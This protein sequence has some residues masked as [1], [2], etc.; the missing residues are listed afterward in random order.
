M[1]AVPAAAGSAVVV[2]GGARGLTARAYGVG[3]AV[4]V[5]GGA[6]GLTA[7]AY[8]VGSAVVRYWRS[9]FLK[10]QSK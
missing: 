6:R 4:V 8:G 3:S 7:R 9:C 10:R 5:V 2:V 1:S